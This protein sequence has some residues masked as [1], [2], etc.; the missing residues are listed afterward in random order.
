MGDKDAVKGTAGAAAC[1]GSEDTEHRDDHTGNLLCMV[2]VDSHMGNDMAFDVQQGALSMEVAPELT[3]VRRA[4][5][6]YQTSLSRN[7]E[8]SNKDID[9]ELNRDEMWKVSPVSR[10]RQLAREE[11]EPCFVE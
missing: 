5:L 3:G 4:F 11:H 2:K 8:V 6:A 7:G 9:K 1:M 10:E